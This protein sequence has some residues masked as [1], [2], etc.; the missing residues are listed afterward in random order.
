MNDY[1]WSDV[2]WND[3]YRMVICEV[4][5]WEVL[6]FVNYDFVCIKELDHRYDRRSAKSSRIIDIPS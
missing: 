6:K 1:L 2:L 4:V 5:I 3:Y